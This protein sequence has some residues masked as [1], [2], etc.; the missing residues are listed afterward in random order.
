MMNMTMNHVLTSNMTEVLFLLQKN[1]RIVDVNMDT[2]S[3]GSGT[4]L[5]QFAGENVLDD[6]G[7]YMRHCPCKLSDLHIA[8]EAI[9]VA[10]EAKLA[11]QKAGE[12]S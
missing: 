9:L 1:N 10:V 2:A 4:F 5:V 3:I 8:F 12:F 6:H 11:R 7:E